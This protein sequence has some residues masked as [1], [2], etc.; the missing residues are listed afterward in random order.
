L[1]FEPGLAHLVRLTTDAVFLPM[2]VEYAWWEERRP[3][4]LL[5]MGTP[6]LFDGAMKR[7][8]ARALNR[9]L[10]SHLDAARRRLTEASINREVEA[11]EV[12]LG[13]RGGTNMA[14]DAW[15][16]FKAALRGK[17]FDAAHGVK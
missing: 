16:W 12:L 5:R 4:I 14:Y 8:P 2:A 13:G 1:K 15:R 7:S 17:H 3:E 6:L 11:F 10:E 9:Q